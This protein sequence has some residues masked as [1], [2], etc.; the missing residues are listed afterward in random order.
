MSIKAKR[1]GALSAE[2]ILSSWYVFVNFAI[3]CKVP[4]IM[5][6]KSFRKSKKRKKTAMAAKRLAK[7]ISKNVFVNKGYSS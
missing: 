6:V 7:G 2:M 4:I 5:R 1:T 3:F